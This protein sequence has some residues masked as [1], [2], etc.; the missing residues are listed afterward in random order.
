MP[1]W[2]GP[3]ATGVSK[4]ATPSLEWSETKNIRWKVEIPVAARHADRLGDRLFLL[5]RFRPARPSSVACSAR[6]DASPHRFQVLATIAR[7]RPRRLGAHRP[8]EAP[9]ETSHPEN[10]T[11]A[12]SSAV[13]N[14]EILI[15]SFESRGLYAYDM[16]GTPLWQTDLGDKAMRNQFGEGSTP[17]LFGNRL[18]VVWDHTAGSFVAGLDARTA[19]NVGGRSATNRHWARRCRVVREGC[20]F[21]RSGMTRHSYDSD[22]RR[23]LAHAGL[24]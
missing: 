7:D 17:A 18:V 3:Y 15:A 19:S 12:S 16:N 22:L 13:T 4:S 11:W 14:G 1:Q 8:G 20:A 21:H 24:L 5:T 23:G 6:I 10:G 2:R 9:H